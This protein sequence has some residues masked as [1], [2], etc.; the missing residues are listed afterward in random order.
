MNVSDKIDKKIAEA[1]E[2]ITSKGLDPLTLPDIEKEFEAVSFNGKIIYHFLY[3]TL[4]CHI[5]RDRC[6]LSTMVK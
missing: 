4:T 1:R 5:C 3:K 2:L 6:Y